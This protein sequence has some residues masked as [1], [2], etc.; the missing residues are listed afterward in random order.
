MEQL[1]HISLN[2]AIFTVKGMTY[3]RNNK[4]LKSLG[5]FQALVDDECLKEISRHQNLQRLSLQHTLITDQGLLSLY[6][7]KDLKV[8]HLSHTEVTPS[9][10]A[11]LKK[12][13]PNCYIP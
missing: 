11:K 12:V 10:V 7:L 6:S 4:N 9:G 2:G 5:F 1:E 13:F 8:L 3:L